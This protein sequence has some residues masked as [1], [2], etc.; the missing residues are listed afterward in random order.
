VSSTTGNTPRVVVG[1]TASAASRW[2]LAWAVGTARRYGMPLTVVAAFAPPATAGQYGVAVAVVGR[3][4]AKAVVDQAFVE[5]CGG[6]PDDL[7]VEVTCV[8]A[9]AGRALT[10][11]AGVGDLLVIGSSGRLRGA[12]RRFCARH[13]PCPLVIVPC[14]DASDLL[15]RPV[16]TVR[17]IVR[18]PRDD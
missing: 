12:T 7:R 9:S 14:P 3:E 6:M 10:S 11:T 5:V 16:R 8:M 17:R 4:D 2:A 18:H 15:G 1:V 13:T